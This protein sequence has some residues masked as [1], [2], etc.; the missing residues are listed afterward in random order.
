MKLST[1]HA[2]YQHRNQGRGAGTTKQLSADVAN[3]PTP[4]HVAMSG[5]R[6]LKRVFGIEIEGCAGCGGR[7][8]IIAR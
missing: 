3:P 5:A 7:L 1:A 6:R 4:R 8:K 2:G